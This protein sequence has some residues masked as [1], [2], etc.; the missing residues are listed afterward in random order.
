MERP[1]GSRSTSSGDHYM[2]PEP[3]PP[4]PQDSQN[5]LTLSLAIIGA[6]TGTSSALNAIYTTARDRPRLRLD[7]HI[8]ESM[9]HPP[10]LLVSVTNVGRRPTTVREV[11]F[12]SD[13]YEFKHYAD[14]ESTEVL[15][16]GV[17]EVGCIVE[18]AIFLEAGE[19][20]EFDATM[21]VI[22]MQGWADK[23]LRLYAR[24][25]YGKRVWGGASRAVRQL[26]GPNPPLDRLPDELR[27]MLEKPTPP[28]HQWPGKVEPRWKVWKKRELRDPKAW[29]G[30]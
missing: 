25:I 17:G 14:L 4:T 1:K 7:A 11:G 22:G 30:H 13:L 28:E 3:M 9:A 27:V 10:K 23:P 8:I 5:T 2:L 26:F 16:T 19:S 21:N 18:R 15:H 29:K 6:V 24:D 20:K 12:Y